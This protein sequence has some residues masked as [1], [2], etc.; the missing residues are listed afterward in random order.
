[1]N[2]VSPG[3]NR[4]TEKIRVAVFGSFYR[5]FYVL[6]E[7]LSGP[8]SAN[9]I[10][11]GVATD[12]P[13]QNFVSPQKRLW[14]YP[15]TTQEEEMVKNLARLSGI[16]TYSGRVKTPEFYNIM[17]SK[18]QPDLCVTATF[19]QKID[20]RLFN[21]PPLGF[22][23][24]HP[25]IDDAWPSRYAG[26][27]PF[28][29]LIDDH[30][31]YAVLAMHRVNE[32]FDSGELIAYSEKIYIPDHVDVIDLH[33]ITSPIAGKFAAREVAR[34]IERNATSANELSQEH[35]LVHAP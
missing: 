8:L 2:L 22:Y 27:N 6:K 23:N 14:Q 33:K 1:M 28:Q 31:E 9:L 24:F 11:V 15:H 12:D 17:E 35:G 5:G 18:W 4:R 34:I 13:T 10:V 32:C 29:A 7:L 30:R 20:S 26:C 19:G 16:D 25:C 3:S 21:A